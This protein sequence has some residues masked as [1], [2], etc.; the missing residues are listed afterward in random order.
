LIEPALFYVIRCAVPS[1][2]TGSNKETFKGTTGTIYSP[3]YPRNYHNNEYK[4]YKIIAPS[5]SK[6]VLTF[7][8]FDVEYN[9]DCS[10]DSLKARYFVS[11]AYSAVL[12]ELLTASI[13]TMS[14]YNFW[15]FIV[16][17]NCEF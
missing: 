13:M 16:N 4:E 5:L 9:Y 10:Y 17:R 12:L 14:W 2:S 3:N 11:F 6:I 8:E 1:S 15:V 7:I